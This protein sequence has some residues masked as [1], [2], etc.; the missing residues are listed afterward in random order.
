MDYPPKR[1]PLRPGGQP[2]TANDIGE[3]H[4]QIASFDT[5]EVIADDAREIVERFM[6]DLVDRLPPKRTAKRK[7]TARRKSQRK[8]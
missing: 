4:D 7:V 6:P 5:I 1:T 2:M 8:R 3:L